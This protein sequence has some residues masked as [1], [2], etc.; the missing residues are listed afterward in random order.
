MNRRPDY[1]VCSYCCDK[2]IKIFGT[3]PHGY[4]YE[5]M[6]AGWVCCALNRVSWLLE[7]KCVECRWTSTVTGVIDR[8]ARCLAPSSCSWWACAIARLVADNGVLCMG[9]ARDAEYV[10]GRLALRL[11]WRTEENSCFS[12]LWTP[13]SG[14]GGSAKPWQVCAERVFESSVIK[15]WYVSIHCLRENYATVSS[16]MLSL[17]QNLLNI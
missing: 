1:V 14:V 15:W 17:L 9:N 2:S 3:T 7:Q 10:A 4:R 5:L 13:V 6:L 8:W 11:L 16:S 12:G